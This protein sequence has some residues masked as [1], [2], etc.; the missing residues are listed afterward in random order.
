MEHGVQMLSS[1]IDEALMN[2]CRA[3]EGIASIDTSILRQHLQKRER[4][5]PVA[6]PPAPPP[7]VSVVR[8]QLTAPVD[9]GLLT[10]GHLPA[11]DNSTKIIGKAGT[12]HRPKQVI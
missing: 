11:D 2:D 4:V 7:P 5:A 12:P 1:P 3:L 9:P 10:V 8:P 6:L